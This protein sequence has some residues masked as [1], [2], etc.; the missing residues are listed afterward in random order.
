MPLGAWAR[1]SSS[2]WSLAHALRRPPPLQARPASTS[3]AR[4]RHLEAALEAAAAV[5]QTQQAQPVDGGVSPQVALTLS[6]AKEGVSVLLS[7]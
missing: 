4:P 3:P 2:C 7:V 1:S 6:A 5:P